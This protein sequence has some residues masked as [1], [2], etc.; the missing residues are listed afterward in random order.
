MPDDKRSRG[1]PVPHGLRCSC[2]GCAE[3]PIAKIYRDGYLAGAADRA[4]EQGMRQADGMPPIAD[5]DPDELGEIGRL[6]DYLGHIEP[7][8]RR[9]AL[10]L[11][12]RCREL[13]DQLGRGKRQAPEI[14]PDRDLAARTLAELATREHILQFFQFD[15]LPPFLRAYAQGFAELAIELVGT[16]PDNPQREGALWKLLE[17]KDCAVRA[18]IYKSQEAR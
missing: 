1:A 17:A 6:L 3:T 14:I 2:E 10:R 5:M 15:H 7:A 8:H 18:R 12:V 4:A 16:L 9:A 13:A 11:V